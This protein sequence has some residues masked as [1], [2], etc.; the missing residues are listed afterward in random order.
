MP[1]QTLHID[2]SRMRKCGSVN[3]IYIF[4][5][6]CRTVSSSLAGLRSLYIAVDDMDTAELPRWFFAT[7][8]EPVGLRVTPYHKP[9]GLSHI[10]DTLE[11]DEIEVIRRSS[12]GKFLELVS[13]ACLTAQLQEIIYSS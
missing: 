4:A 9:G 1:L 12:F 11:E 8:D 10:L 13:L 6:P 5:K 7:G 3:S 2:I